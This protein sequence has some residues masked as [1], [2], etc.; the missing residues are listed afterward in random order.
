ML[1]ERSQSQKDKYC[2]D[3]IPKKRRKQSNSC[4]QSRVVVARWE[5]EGMKSCCLMGIG[6]LFCQKKKFWSSSHSNANVLNT[7]ELYIK[8]VKMVNFLCVFFFHN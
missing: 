8:M 5:D 2:C 6:F 7:T 1:S 4:K 3:S